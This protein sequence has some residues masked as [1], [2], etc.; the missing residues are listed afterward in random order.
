VVTKH[1]RPVAAIVALDEEGLEDL[2]LAHAP[3]FVLAMGA[4]EKEDAEGETKPLGDVLD[5]IDAEESADT[6]AR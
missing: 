5:E 1:G 4:A 2:V 6:S 3:E